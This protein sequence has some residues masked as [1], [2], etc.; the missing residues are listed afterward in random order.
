MKTL[1]KNL[2]K[3]FLKS[4]DE[5]VYSLFDTTDHSSDENSE[6]P[7]FVSE[8]QKLVVSKGTPTRMSFEKLNSIIKTKK[9]IFYTGAGISAEAVPTMNILMTRLGIAKNLENDNKLQKYISE[10]M[11]NS[12][13]YTEILRDFWERCESA[14]P[15]KAHIL[16]A[17]CAKKFD[18]LIVTKN[19]DQLHQHSGIQP[20]V[21]SGNDNYSGD[22]KMISLIKTSDYIITVGLNSD[23]SGFLKF[24][25][26]HNPNGKIISVNLVLTNYLSNDDFYVEGN[27]QK[28]AEEIFKLSEK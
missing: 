15:T 24:Y 27:V 28:I 11:Y 4:E 20:M 22:E 19:V 6:T 13:K 12:A 2:Q 26:T 8:N 1:P 18:H 25:K 5:F 9:I 17:E 21:L 23:E 16:L 14:S 3:L 7:N 10:I